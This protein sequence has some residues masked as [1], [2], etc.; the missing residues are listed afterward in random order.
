MGVSPAEFGQ[1][2]AGPLGSLVQGCGL[3]CSCPSHLP[4][5]GDATTGVDED[6]IEFAL[7][8]GEG[9]RFVAIVNRGHGRSYERHNAV[10]DLVAVLAI[11]QR[12]EETVALGYVWIHVRDSS[13]SQELGDLTASQP[14]VCSSQ[15]VGNA[16]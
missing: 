15:N 2:G 4:L 14:S 13:L 1:D 3:T 9:G 11:G 5:V 8:P 12:V 6:F 10:A 16:L 7:E